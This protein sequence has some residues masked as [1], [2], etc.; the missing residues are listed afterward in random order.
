MEGGGVCGLFLRGKRERGR[1]GEVGERGI[2]RRRG[3]EE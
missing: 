3:G 2:R 1:R